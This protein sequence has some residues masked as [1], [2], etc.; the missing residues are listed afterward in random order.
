MSKIPFTT[1]QFIQAFEKYNQAI[2]PF[3][4]VLILVAVIVPIGFA[5]ATVS[6]VASRK[7]FANKL[8]ATIGT[9]MIIRHNL[10]PK[11]EKVLLS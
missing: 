11:M 5:N 10:S 9:T 4:F 1:E 2:Y 8:T 6:L 3:Q 7:P